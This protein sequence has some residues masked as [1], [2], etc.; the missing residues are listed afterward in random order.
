MSAAA[1]LHDSHV[2][3]WRD[4][5]HAHAR[6]FLTRL[7]AEAARWTFQTFD[8]GPPPKR[9]E[10][11][12]VV[13]GDF[14][15]V[16]GKLDALQGQRAG[17]FVTIAATDGKG[18]QAHNIARVRAVF[19]DLDG[20]PLAP[21]LAAGLEPHIVVESSPGKWHCYWCTDDCP[22]D[23]FER[24]QRALARRFGG[25]PSVHDLPRVMRLPGFRH[26]KGEAQTSKLLDGI[27]NSGLPY[28]LAEFVGAL[29]LELDAPE[30]R[31]HA[32]PNGDG[33]MIE[34]GNRHAHL[35]ASGRSMARRGLSPEAVRAA[36]AAENQA[37][38]NPPVAEADIDDLARRAFEAKHAQGWQDAPP[39][40]APG[41]DDA[42]HQENAE[43][44]ADDDLRGNPY[45]EPRDLWK[46]PAP[47]PLLDTAAALPACLAEIVEPVAE[48]RGHD[49]GAL[50]LSVVCAL[51]ACL[52]QASRISAHPTFTTW[53]E[54][55]AV[56]GDL[57]GESGT[58]KTP[59]M[60]FAAA[61]LNEIQAAHMADYLRAKEK[62]GKDDAIAPPA[63][64]IAADSTIEALGVHYAGTVHRML[65]LRDEGT[66]FINGMG[67]YS[68]KGDAERGD[69]CSAWNCQPHTID[70]LTRKSLHFADWGVSLL[71]GLTPSQ[72]KEAAEEARQDGLL[73]RML[74]C[75]VRPVT[76]RERPSNAE[77][78]A[79][80]AYGG[81]ARAVHGLGVVT[82]S[83]T[84]AAAEVFATAR[85][86]FAEAAEVFAGNNKQMAVWLRKAAANSL[87]VALVF[88]AASAGHARI[89]R[90][91]G[92]DV[93]PIVDD[94]AA[95]RAVR[96]VNWAAC[97]A[98]AFSEM[99]TPSPVADLARRVALF[100]LARQYASVARR[101]LAQYVTAWGAEPDERTR[102]AAILHLFDAGWITGPAGTRVTRGP[103]IADATAWHVNPLALERFADYG[104][105]EV[106]R[107]RDVRARMLALGGANA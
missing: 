62:A 47:G 94:A 12:R 85:T 55:S 90:A 96:F 84:P 23:Q 102:G 103:G 5:R 11:A 95:E 30:E 77:A 74:P 64:L 22:L 79:A 41:A 24:V 46:E 43:R 61:P 60:Q 19:V 8:D 106:T 16:A 71:L 44:S 88:A 82:A 34:P 63:R 54:G 38:C 4:W 17:V 107:R 87:R 73:A 72:M 56:W 13:N 104:A 98:L 37:R 68:G 7:D 32:R 66:G 20:A 50:A 6:Q 101:D 1:A 75:V 86:H 39:R 51:S 92:G 15:R 76:G 25:D 10:L 97:H 105:A 42:P 70:R 18:R 28:A 81:L 52:R 14:E 40:D 59:S 33:G 78:L 29:H 58:G 83:P 69:W 89:G 67:R 21:V 9:R 80:L 100:V 91:S 49:V 45:P 3:A 99:N 57:I 48:A 53:Q 65:N 2:T 35:F 31:P 27:G 26:F 93:A 36:L